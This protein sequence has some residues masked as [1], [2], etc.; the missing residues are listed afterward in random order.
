MDM[1]YMLDVIDVIIK[2]M[3][4]D[5]NW[6]VYWNVFNILVMFFEFEEIKVFI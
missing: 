6:L 4:V 5:F 2:F 1:M 3:N